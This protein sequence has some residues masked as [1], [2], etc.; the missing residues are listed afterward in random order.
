MAWFHLELKEFYRREKAHKFVIDKIVSRHGM[1]L[2]TMCVWYNSAI[3]RIMTG[4]GYSLQNQPALLVDVDTIG[5]VQ[6]DH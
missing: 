6:V 3:L 1:W 2:P 4:S 5:D